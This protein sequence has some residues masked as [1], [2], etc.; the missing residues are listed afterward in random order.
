SAVVPT[1]LRA[2]LIRA[3]ILWTS[4]G[5]AGRD[6]PGDL[7]FLGRKLMRIRQVG[8]TSRLGG[9]VRRRRISYWGLLATA[10]ALL[11]AAGVGGGA[12]YA[13][14]VQ[15]GIAVTKGCNSP[16]A[17]GQPY[18]CTYV[19]RNTIDEAQDTLTVHSLVDVVHASGGD[20]SS[21]DVFSSLSLTIGAFLP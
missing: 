2:S 3:L 14:D 20:V 5:A 10:T 6:R 13:A 15:H 8:T 12:A 17:I 19:I 21:G 4:R 16:T 18:S 7:G 1:T 11:V 9:T